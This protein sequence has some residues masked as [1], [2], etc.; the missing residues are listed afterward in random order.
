MTEL[1]ATMRVA[2]R[3]LAAIEE[4]RGGPTS[5]DMSRLREVFPK[6]AKWPPNELA[7]AVIQEAAQE[8]LEASRKNQPNRQHKKR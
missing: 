2:L 8:C 4:K 3:A 7:C 6:G 1:L 5:A